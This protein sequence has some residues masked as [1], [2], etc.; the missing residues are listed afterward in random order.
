MLIYFIAYTALVIVFSLLVGVISLNAM[1]PDIETLISGT[2]I[3]NFTLLN[4]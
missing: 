4:S 3:A 2:D 1:Q